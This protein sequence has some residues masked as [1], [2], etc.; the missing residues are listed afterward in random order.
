VVSFTPRSLYPRGKSSWYP[1]DRRL[2]EPQSRYGRHVEVKILDH[3][4]T[5]TPTPHSSSLQGIAVLT[6]LSR[7]IIIIIT[8][9]LTIF[10]IVIIIIYIPSE[11]R[12]DLM[13]IYA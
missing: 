11:V 8:I 13:A 12:F 10:V 2:G 3:T 5:G 9:K 1:L 7:L 6:A 4:G